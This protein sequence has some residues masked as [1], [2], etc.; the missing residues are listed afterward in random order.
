MSV[1]TAFI[2]CKRENLTSTFEQS[3]TGMAAF[4][5]KRERHFAEPLPTLRN[6]L[7]FHLAVKQ[8]AL[9]V[10]TLLNLWLFTILVSVTTHADPLKL[11]TTEWCPY[12]CFEQ[13]E[14]DNFIGRYLTHVFKQLGIE[15]SLVSYPWARSVNLAENG[16]VDGLLTAVKAEAPSLLFTS[17]P[18]AYYQVC[19]Y[20]L[21]PTWTYTTPDD[22]KSKKLGIIRNYGYAQEIDNYIADPENQKRLEVVSGERATA[23]LVQMLISDRTEV[24]VEDRLVLSREAQKHNIDISLVRN[25]GCTKAEPYYVAIHPSVESAAQTIAALNVALRLPAN[26]DYLVEISPKL[27]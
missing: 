14:Q 16:A 18:I 20:T 11:A 25:A 10:R 26:L 12:T 2:D 3:L 15:L 9:M 17:T 8:K 13:S 22:L 5:T 1:H 6:K 27:K 19:L 7:Y 4:F 23:R 24:I 21:D